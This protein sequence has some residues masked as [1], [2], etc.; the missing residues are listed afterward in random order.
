MYLTKDLYAE[1]KDSH[2]SV[3]RKINIPIKNGQ[4]LEK[5]LHKEIF[6]W[7]VMY[8][9]VCDITNHWEIQMKTTSA[10]PPEQIQFRRLSVAGVKTWNA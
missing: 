2:I 3:I 10:H 8:K 9:K 6:R 7:S 5:E 1:Y 4:K